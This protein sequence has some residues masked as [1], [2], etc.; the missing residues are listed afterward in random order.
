MPAAT[1]TRVTVVSITPAVAGLSAE[2]IGNDFELRLH[3]PDG[4]EVTVNR[5]AGERPLRAVGGTLTWREHRLRHPLPDGTLQIGLTLAGEPVVIDLRSRRG[6]APSPWPP[7]VLG[8]IALA[9]GILRPRWAAGLAVGAFVAMLLGAAGG[10]LEGR[11]V[12]AAVVLCVVVTG[13]SAA[14]VL[15]IAAVPARFRSLTA[16]AVAAVALLLA[17]AQV[18]MLYRAY[19]VSAL[20]DVVAHGLETVALALA[21]AALAAVVAGRP[22][23][24]FEGDDAGVP[25]AG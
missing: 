3:L 25:P 20:P 4:A 2:V 8:L 16:G 1:A 21:V 18:P 19:P 11:G 6:S 13:L 5:S 14:A 17:M 15:A 9:V 12:L 23:R 10:F 7:L 24:A 22:W